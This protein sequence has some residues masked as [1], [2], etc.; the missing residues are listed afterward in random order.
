MIWLYNDCLKEY[1]SAYQIKKAVR[2]GRL[3]KI[4]Q[5][6]YSDKPRVSTLAIIS[7]KYLQAIITMDQVGVELCR[8]TFP[9]ND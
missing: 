9:A 2:D 7:A 3:Y 6:I 5:G 1:K 4:E 8:K